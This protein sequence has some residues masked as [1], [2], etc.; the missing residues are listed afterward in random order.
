MLF[1]NHNIASFTARI[2]KERCPMIDIEHTFLHTPSTMRALFD[3][4]GFI[5]ISVFGVR[6]DY[7]LHYWAHLLP[8]P[9]TLKMPIVRFL[10][11]SP[12]E[13]IVIPLYAGNL[14]LIARKS[15]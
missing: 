10:K 7:P 13:R 11:H 9:Q 14:G 5:D 12:L 15:L 1:I 3:E 4:K 2:L 8:G 6:N